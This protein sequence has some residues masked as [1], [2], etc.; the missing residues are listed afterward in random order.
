[1]IGSDTRPPCAKPDCRRNN[2]P[3]PPRRDPRRR[4][5]TVRSKAWASQ[6]GRIGSVAFPP[7]SAVATVVAKGGLW[8]DHPSSR[9]SYR[10]WPKAAIDVAPIG[11]ERLSQHQPLRGRLTFRPSPN[12][13]CLR[14]YG[15]AARPACAKTPGKR[16]GFP[17]KERKAKPSDGS[18]HGLSMFR[19]GIASTN[20]HCIAD[21]TTRFNNAKGNC[22]EPT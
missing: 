2:L 3:P 19:L 22:S 14:C 1:M 12:P 8:S 9:R 7:I 10:L 11:P 5:V 13:A 6:A 16:E 20:A 4:R 21:L 17:R 15:S 18:S